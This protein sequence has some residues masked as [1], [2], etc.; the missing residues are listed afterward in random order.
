MLKN[1]AALLSLQAALRRMS[2]K[3]WCQSW[4]SSSTSG[5]TWTWSTCWEPAQSLEVSETIEPLHWIHSATSNCTGSQTGS[6][7]F[8]RPSLSLYS[9][10][11]LWM[12]AFVSFRV[13]R[14]RPV[15]DDRG[16][17][18]VRQPVQLPAWQK[19]GLCR[20]QGE[21]GDDY[22]EK[23]RGKWCWTSL[24]AC[25]AQS[26][27][28]NGVSSGSGFELS[29]LMKRRLESV[30]STG[31][32]ASSGFIEDKSYC[33]SEEEE[34]GKRPSQAR[35][36][37]PPPSAHHHPSPRGSSPAP[38][39][40]E[41]TP[42]PLRIRLFS[43]LRL[44]GR[45]LLLF[46]STITAAGAAVTPHW[47]WRGGCLLPVPNPTAAAFCSSGTS[48]TSVAVVLFQ[49]WAACF[50]RWSSGRSSLWVPLWSGF[51]WPRENR[52]GIAFLSL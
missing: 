11:L 43:S 29:E 17:L 3:L 38:P 20:L 12:C 4:R 15:N 39:P 10:M 51:T 23:P 13:C 52:R 42:S 25:A 30:A 24:H 8:C 34:E 7:Q 44:I 45:F 6:P 27:D 1:K 33:D 22:L 31:S 50:L 35:P 18:Q 41:R 16:I 40:Q 19:R 47:V 49:V 14:D 37:S 46:R 32:S 2:V 48:L 5:I 28:G 36:A 9:Y 26:Q 21:S